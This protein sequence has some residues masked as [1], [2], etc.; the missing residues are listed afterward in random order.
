M[1]YKEKAELSWLKNDV[2]E[3]VKG[4]T[5][6]EI[7]GLDFS[8]SPPNKL[9]NE[10]Q[11]NVEAVKATAEGGGTFK[12]LSDTPVDIADPADNGKIVTIDSGGLIFTSPGTA[13]NKNFVTSGGDNG[14]STDVAR[15]DHTHAFYPKVHVSNN[16]NNEYQKTYASMAINVWHDL[17]L[18]DLVGNTPT[19]PALTFPRLFKVVIFAQYIAAVAGYEVFYLGANPLLTKTIEPPP[20]TPVSGD[21]AL[22]SPNGG[23]TGGITFFAWLTG[24]NDIIGRFYTIYANGNLKINLFYLEEIG[25]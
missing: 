15:G 6:S 16:L 10:L 18:V 23:Y 17:L 14:T 13:F 4:S 1:A 7:T 5:P 20:P 9:I 24:L 22:R 2:S 25:S 12:A 8:T 19:L 11:D 21:I 3:L